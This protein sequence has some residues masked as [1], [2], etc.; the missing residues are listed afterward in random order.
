MGSFEDDIVL[1]DPIKTTPNVYYSRM[2]YKDE[3]LSIQINNADISL[4][5]NKGKAKIVIDKS[6]SEFIKNISAGIIQITSDK[7][8]DFFGKKI[9]V[10]DCESIYKEALV[11]DNTLHC[12]FDDETYFYE[13]RNKN[14]NIEDINDN[15]Q[16]IVLLKCSAVVYTRSS[17]FTRWE[18]SQ[19]KIKTK[20]STKEKPILDYSIRDLP[21]DDIPLADDPLHRKLKEICLF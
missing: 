6:T 14:I 10:E 20:K 16:G 3:E 17:F 12:F 21:E 7:S 1:Y 2:M 11:N 9:N 18:I 13:S 19:L 15:I 8:E 5:K 4:N